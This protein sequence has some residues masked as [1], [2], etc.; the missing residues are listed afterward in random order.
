M[1]ATNNDSTPPATAGPHCPMGGGH[2]I[3]PTLI[4]YNV[5]QEKML[6]V[7]LYRHEV[8][9]KERRGRS[10]GL[11]LDYQLVVRQ[12]QLGLFEERSETL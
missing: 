12:T 7:A 6:I 5:Q 3:A 1:A 8:L 2:H 4:P 9:P 11:R 10:C